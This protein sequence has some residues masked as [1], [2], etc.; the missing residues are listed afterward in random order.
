MRRRYGQREACRICGQDIEWSGKGHGWTDRGGNRSCV[1]P[2]PDDAHDDFPIVGLDGKMRR[3]KRKI[4][5]T[6]HEPD[7]SCMT[8]A[9]ARAAYKKL[10]TTTTPKEFLA[11]HGN[12]GLTEKE[13]EDATRLARVIV[14]KGGR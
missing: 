7:I 2:A 3:L 1:L 8:K 13:H 4:P 5:V 6:K 9:E 10:P 11:G 14:G 12:W